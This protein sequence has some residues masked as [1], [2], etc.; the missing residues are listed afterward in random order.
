MNDSKMMDERG[1]ERETSSKK[2]PSKSP[3]VH[4]LEIM[5]MLKKR[6][7]MYARITRW[8]REYIN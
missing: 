5:S 6:E 4:S 2:A 3:V 1:V 7:K 8:A